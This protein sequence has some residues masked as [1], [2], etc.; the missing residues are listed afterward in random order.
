MR[1]TTQKSAIPSTMQAS[2]VK[3]AARES[4]FSFGESVTVCA[5]AGEECLFSDGCFCTAKKNLISVK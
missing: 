1:N 2:P 3:A 5:T 4:R